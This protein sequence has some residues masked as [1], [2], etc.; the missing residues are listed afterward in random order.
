MIQC[1]VC[2]ILI[3]IDQY[4]DNMINI[5]QYTIPKSSPFRFQAST[6]PGNT[7]MLPDEHAQ[8][9]FIQ[10]QRRHRAGVGWA[11]YSQI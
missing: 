8:R 2:T 1:N 9:V 7:A 6:R 11:R 3:N 10:I 4:N 5:H